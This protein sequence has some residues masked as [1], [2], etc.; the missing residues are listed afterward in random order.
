M[1]YAHYINEPA[2]YGHD[3]DNLIAWMLRAMKNNY[4]MMMKDAHGL[5]YD[6]KF[7]MTYKFIE[8]HKEA[9]LRVLETDARIC[10]AKQDEIE[11]QRPEH[12]K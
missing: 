4:L 3:T 12:L 10:A 7:K 8:L 11:S 2:A 1:L 6:K 5:Q 9:I